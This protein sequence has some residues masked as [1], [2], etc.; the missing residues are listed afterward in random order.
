MLADTQIVVVELDGTSYGLPAGAVTHVIPMVRV[1]PLRGGPAIVAGVIDVHGAVVPVIDLR[2][3]L[4][5][6]PRPARPD[7]HLVIADAAGRTVA[8]HVDR[9]TALAACGA[10][11]PVTGAHTRHLAGIGR[12]A[13]GL[14]VVTDLDAFLT[15]DEEAA[16]D[17]AL[18]ESPAP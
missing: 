5:H 12:T 11:E 13:D 18:T 6:Q 17:R 1:T 14:L 7:D 9:A 16:L 4:G 8:L 15:Q 2:S 3:R 10:L